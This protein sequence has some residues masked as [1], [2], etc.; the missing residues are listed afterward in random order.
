ML[1]KYGQAEKS[2]LEIEI[3]LNGTFS[4]PN[5]LLFSK[6][7]KSKIYTAQLLNYFSKQIFCNGLS[8]LMSNRDVA[9]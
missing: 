2:Q 7:L 4:I 1:L 9:D 3:L 5:A 8:A 6:V